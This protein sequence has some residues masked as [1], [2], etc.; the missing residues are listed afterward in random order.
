M[1]PLLAV[2]LTAALI[3]FWLMHKQK[4]C[5]LCTTRSA[6][7]VKLMTIAQVSH[8][9]SSNHIVVDDRCDRQRND[10]VVRDANVSNE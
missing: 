10:R 1:T 2:A 5:V 7:V 3:L 9:S 8:A 4:S 6:R